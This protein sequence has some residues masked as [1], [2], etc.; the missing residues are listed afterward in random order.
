[1]RPTFLC[2]FVLLTCFGCYGEDIV[3][4]HGVLVGGP[5]GGDRDCDDVCLGGGDFPGGTCSV[6]CR[7]DRD[8]P[9]GTACIDKKGGVCLLLCDRNA[10][11][12]DGYKCDGQGRRGHSGQEYVCID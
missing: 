4:N 8:C 1:M 7:D 11:C 9:R 6:E 12:R 5:C 2:L 3:G 10:D